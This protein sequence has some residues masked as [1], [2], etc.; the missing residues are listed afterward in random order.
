MDKICIERNGCAHECFSKATQY[1][2][3]KITLDKCKVFFRTSKKVHIKVPM[4]KTKFDYPYALK[5]LVSL[6]E[7][8]HL[9]LK[10]GK[11]A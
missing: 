1:E 10:I 6:L 7:Y 8:N 11:N 4:K 5:D 9:F 2:A 3:D